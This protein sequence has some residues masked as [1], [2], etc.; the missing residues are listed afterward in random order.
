[1]LPCHTVDRLPG[2]MYD[3]IA[4]GVRSVSGGAF[5]RAACLKANGPR[6]DGVPPKSSIPSVRT[7][8]SACPRHPSAQAKEPGR[9]I[10]AAGL[11]LPGL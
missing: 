2:A 4:G 10:K 5:Y 8:A 11:P 3:A 1:M 6:P 9:R 7:P